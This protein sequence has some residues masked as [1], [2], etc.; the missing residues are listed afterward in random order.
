MKKA[1]VDRE[2]ADGQRFEFGEN[3]KK[4]L[5]ALNDERI[6]AAESS[7]KEM[8]EVD[9]L[10]GRTFLDIGCGSGLFSLA[11]RN[12]GAEVRSFDY[13]RSS[14]WCTAELKNRY[15]KDDPQWIVE[16]GSV[17]DGAYLKSLGAFDIV[18]SWGVLHHT[19]EMW[20][21]LDNV[22]SS[23]ED[24]GLLFIAIYNQQP[25]ASGY[26]SFVKRSYNSSRLMRPFWVL[27]HLLY[28]TI[29]S[30]LLK[31]LRGRKPPRGMT[32]WYDLL[33]WLGGYPFEVAAPRRIFDF[34]RARG[35]TLM[36]LETVGGKHGCNEYVFRKSKAD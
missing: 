12:L 14:V 20:A 19:G 31:T 9:N 35:F 18:Y 17:L 29:P 36:Q 8:L 30:I 25:F 28:P 4:F 26:W 21:A 32:Y 15:H 33:D 11:A 1:Q 22:C 34:Y 13:D 6:A 27:L 24:G 7:L 10:E 3:W 23:V 5:H 16:Q 2:V